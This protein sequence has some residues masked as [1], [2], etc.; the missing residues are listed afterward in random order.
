MAF[1]GNVRKHRL[2]LVGV[3]LLGFVQCV[4]GIQGCQGGHDHDVWLVAWERLTEAK[5]V[6]F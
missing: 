1:Q 5:K 4:Q 3:G 2:V 6:G